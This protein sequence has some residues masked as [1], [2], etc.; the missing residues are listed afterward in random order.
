MYDYAIDAATAG[1][2]KIER[3]GIITNLSYN[4]RKMLEM[5]IEE[6]APIINIITWN[7]YPEGHHLAPEV[8]HNYGFSVLLNHY[9]AI[10]KGEPS[11]YQNKDVAITFF[12]K[13]KYNLVPSPYN[14]PIVNIGQS[15]NPTD[16]DSIEV[17]TII[18]EPAQLTVN[19]KTIT[20]KAG[21]VSSKF[22]MVP[23]K[24]N[25]AVTR[26]NAPVLSFKTP[27]GITDKPYRTDRLIYSYSSE[28]LNFHK[29]IFGN[30]PILE[31]N[32]Y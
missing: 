21:V 11:P 31:S 26:K 19:N 5:A 27:E 30:L 9:K 8:N 16:E 7:D 17:V 14:V 12:K 4:Y 2:D 24:V 6:D 28:C 13:Y 10:W 15:V 25:V 20:V 32:E 18:K 29:S 1:I 3:K 22:D 23:G